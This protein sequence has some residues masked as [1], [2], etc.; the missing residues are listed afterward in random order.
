VTIP[1]PASLPW[2]LRDGQPVRITGG[3][4][5]FDGVEV[6]IEKDHTTTDASN[7]LYSGMIHDL[8]GSAHAVG[9]IVWIK[10]APGLDDQGKPIWL[11]VSGGSAER[12]GEYRGQYHGTAPD[13]TT[14]F[15]F[16]QFTPGLP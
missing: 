2:Y 14:I 12:A 7:K 6:M 9:E 10:Q 1:L 11:I 16:I 3:T 8:N 5:P 13:G 4:G 15:E